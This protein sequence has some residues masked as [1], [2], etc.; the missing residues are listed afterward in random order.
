MYALVLTAVMLRRTI[1]VPSTIAVK[2]LLPHLLVM[3]II[4]TFIKTVQVT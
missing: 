1:L 2:D 4:T 3:T